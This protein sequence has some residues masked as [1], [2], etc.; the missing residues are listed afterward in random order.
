MAQA[1]SGAFGGAREHWR[2]TQAVQ[3]QCHNQLLSIWKVIVSE[4]AFL[5]RALCGGALGVKAVS[6]IPLTLPTIY[7]VVDATVGASHQIQER[8]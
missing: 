4:S 7:R 3:W 5:R 8:N 1:H 6:Y 2:G